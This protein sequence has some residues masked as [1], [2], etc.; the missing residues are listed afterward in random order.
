LC[1]FPLCLI[2]Y[3]FW[4]YR[5]EENIRI[6]TSIVLSVFSVFI[7]VIVFSLYSVV[8]RLA[9]ENLMPVIKIIVL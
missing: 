9:V 7:I 2:Q 6:S 4:E 1:L 8:P 5:M 3:F